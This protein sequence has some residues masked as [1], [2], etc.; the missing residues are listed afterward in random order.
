M[1][2]PSP[3][4]F[5][6]SAA[7]APFP[8]A[9]WYLVLWGLTLPWTE[10]SVGDAMCPGPPPGGCPALGS[11]SIGPVGHGVCHFVDPDPLPTSLL[12]HSLVEVRGTVVI[13]T[14]SAFAA[15]DVRMSFSKYRSEAVVAVNS[16]AT[17]ARIRF[18]QAHQA[19]SAQLALH[20]R[21][22]AFPRVD[23]PPVS[24]FPLR[25]MWRASCLLAARCPPSFPCFSHSTLC[26]S[27][28]P[29]AS[30]DRP[31]PRDSLVVRLSA[32]RAAIPRG[33]GLASSDERG[34]ERPL[35]FSVQNVRV[36]SLKLRLALGRYATWYPFDV[37]RESGTFDGTDGTGASD[38]SATGP[39][40][41][42]HHHCDSARPPGLSPRPPGGD[43]RL[44]VKRRRKR[45]GDFGYAIDNIACGGIRIGEAK[46]P[47]PPAGCLAAEAYALGNLGHGVSHFDGPDVP[48]P[49]CEP[50]P[51]EYGDAT[52][53]SPPGSERGDVL[54]PLA[55]HSET[56]PYPLSFEN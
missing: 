16:K 56:T 42:R 30:P 35:V 14:A 7:G 21:P 19:A 33:V 6:A 43:L 53:H 22:G 51:S 39:A 27:C 55:S 1:L 40:W 44:N 54:I 4:R 25:L 2:A 28:R 38:C 32:R 8:P 29:G 24:V 10:V 20:R 15:V 23:C 3:V 5:L 52:Q 37:T 11:H 26:A 13:P 45:L 49:D 48:L 34:L 12:P 18:V 47:G 17:G 46:R 50:P 9:L 31:V 36:A 41:L